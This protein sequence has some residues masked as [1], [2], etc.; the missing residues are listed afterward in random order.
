MTPPL[1][2]F[3]YD[4]SSPLALEEVGA[5]ERDGVRVAELRYDD[6]TG[7]R[8]AAYLVE[9]PDG[10]T[11]AG[12]VVAHGGNGPG[13]HIFVDELVLFARAGIAALAG[14]TSM[15]PEGNA[16][17]DRLA[18]RAAVL[19]QR[20][21]LDVL[22]ARG[23]WRL[24]FYGH[25]FGGAQGAILAAVE[26]RLDAIVI[27]ATGGGT[28]KWLREEGYDEAYVAAS[29]ELFE[30]STWA[31]VPGRRQL[32]FQAGRHD[33]VI[34]IPLARALF[35]AAAEPKTWRDYD[36]DHGVDAD[37]AARADRIAFLVE[38]LL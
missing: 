28:E 19:V 34:P 33:P 22:A 25:S 18:L 26:P 23:A 11:R 12:V 9:P 32:L 4:A 5:F 30:P 8:A 37:P 20:R 31:A 2:L 16:A 3:A 36:W 17:A 35:E 6:G 38:H 24:G 10:E 29:V 21:G 15:P 1:D 7:G 13:K 27:A 14:D